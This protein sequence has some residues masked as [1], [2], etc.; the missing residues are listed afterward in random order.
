[1]MKTHF[2]RS[3]RNLIAYNRVKFSSEAPT[4]EKN[5]NFDWVGLIVFGGMVS[6]IWMVFLKST[7]HVNVLC[8]MLLIYCTSFSL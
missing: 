1:M 6:L 4:I 7:D 5:A 2:P 3:F 8:D